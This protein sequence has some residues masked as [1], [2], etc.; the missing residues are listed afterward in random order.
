MFS[1]MLAEV[2][3]YGE[4]LII[5]DQIP[6]KLT[7]EVLKNTNTKIIHKIFAQDDK[8]A[9]GNTMALSDEQKDFLSFLDQ[10]R[11]VVFS[12]GW[13]GG[14]QVQIV[15]DTDTDSKELVDEKLI[16]ERVLDYYCDIFDLGIYPSLKY[17]EKP[18]TRELFIKH[19]EYRG[20]L[21]SFIA[22]FQGLWKDYKA[23]QDFQ[24]TIGKLEEILSIEKQAEYIRDALYYS[25]IDGS[26]FKAII[27]LLG[28]V[29]G[30]EFNVEEY[31]NILSYGRRINK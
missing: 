14:L 1:D 21:D 16:R 10:G 29:K 27:S 19:L 25:D 26:K 13:D 15:R 18:P 30:G 9:V 31:N 5:V 11:A 3:K 12:Q 17:N 24:D 2:R 4:A 8:E 22:G 20:I 28:K 6:G 7:P 23:T